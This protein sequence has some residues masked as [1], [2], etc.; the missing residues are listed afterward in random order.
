[1]TLLACHHEDYST[2]RSMC[3][4]PNLLI[5]IMLVSLIW[6]LGILLYQQ[7]NIKLAGRSPQGVLQLY[8]NVHTKILCNIICAI[9][10]PGKIFD[11]NVSFLLSEGPS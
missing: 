8:W 6:R 7:Q 10:T 1:M 9:W 2:P 3:M 11:Q 4:Y 5:I